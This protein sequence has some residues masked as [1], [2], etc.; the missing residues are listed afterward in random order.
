MT[1]GI[2]LFYMACPRRPYVNALR[3]Y[4]NRQEKQFKRNFLPLLRVFLI[5]TVVYTVVVKII[6]K[7]IILLT[8]SCPPKYGS[9]SAILELCIKRIQNRTVKTGINL[10]N[11][12]MKA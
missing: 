12:T 8:C 6:S 10:K 1:A 7:I 4:V 11:S 2:L 9:S 5:V 3:P